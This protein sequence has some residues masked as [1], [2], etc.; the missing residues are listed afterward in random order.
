[1]LLND[2]VVTSLSVAATRSRSAKVALLA[3]LIARFGPDQIEIGVGF[4]IG[5]PR[6]RRLNVGWATAWKDKTVA[7]ENPT[8]TLLDVDRCFQQLA[9][10]SGTG[11]QTARTALVTELFGRATAD[12]QN[13]LRRLIV[14]E[15]RQG[16]LE[17]VVTDAVAKA[18]GVPLDIVRRAAM[19]TGDIGRTSVIA[20]TAGLDGLNEI[21]LQVLQPVQPMLASTAVSVSEAVEQIGPSSIEW[22]LDGIRIQVHRDGDEVRIFTR[23]LNDVTRRFPGVV[24]IIRSLPASRVILDGELIGLHEDDVPRLFQETA[25]SFGSEGRSN[26]TLQPFFFDCLHAD[27]IDLI[28]MPLFERQQTLARV[29]GLMRIPTLETTDGN[30][31]SA[32]SDEA[33]AAGHEGVMVKALDSLYEAGRRGK[34]WRKVKPVRTLDLI[35]L[36]AEW[37]HGRRQ[38]WLSN[39]H[40]GA[41]GP[42]G[43]VM[44]GKTFKGMTDA[45]LTWQTEQFLER[46]VEERGIEVHIRPELV[47]EIAV[48]GVQKSTRYPGGVALRFA[49]VKRYRPDKS[50]G[51]ADT[52]EAVQALLPPS[53]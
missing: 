6:Q 3:E 4:L 40:L 18:A 9:D 12:E 39:L 36:A 29:A 30:A 15:M 43:P 11:S 38:G 42:D 1:V 14:G 32:F 37:G 24:E 46:K 51:D 48:D 31:A 5:E 16:A 41:R 49:R 17:G 53:R 52:I 45:L 20:G 22:K 13:Y 27:G 25:G 26:I 23:N 10:A 33:L 21:G 44:V 28:D 47:V 50:P 2:L 34:S 35:V 7:A 8:V 19:L